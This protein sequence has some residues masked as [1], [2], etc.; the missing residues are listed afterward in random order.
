MVGIGDKQKEA[1]RSIASVLLTKVLGKMTLK[2]WVVLG[3]VQTRIVSWK[4]R[5]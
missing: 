4:T 5:N 1:S 2:V 3:L